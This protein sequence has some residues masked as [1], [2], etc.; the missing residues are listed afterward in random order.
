M[1]ITARL[2]LLTR[3]SGDRTAWL[4]RTGHRRVVNG[5]TV[6]VCTIA[7]HGTAAAQADPSFQASASANGVNQSQLG[8][9]IA[10]ASSD[11]AATPAPG[12]QVNARAFATALRGAVGVAAQSTLTASL[13]GCDEAFCSSS[14][15]AGASMVFHDLRFEGPTQD[16]EVRLHLSIGGSLQNSSGFTLAN[17]AISAAI[18][19]YVAQARINVSA[20]IE[21]RKGIL[22]F[23]RGDATLFSFKDARPPTS[24]FRVRDAFGSGQTCHGTPFGTSDSAIYSGYGWTTDPFIVPTG[25]N[26][27]LTV[28]ISTDS[29]TSMASVPEDFIVSLV[30]QSQFDHT[31][32]FPRS[33]PVFDLPDGY[34]VSSAQA[35]I[36]V[37]QWLGTEATD[38]TIAPTIAIALS[39]S[40]NA[41]GWH[42][43]EVV[44]SVSAEDNAGG[45]GVQSITCN[46]AGAQ[47]F[48]ESMLEGGSRSL[49]ITAEGATTVTCA[50]QD[51][52]G[53][54]S[55]RAVVVVR[56]DATPPT[57]RFG[58]PSPLANQA[59]WNNTDVS[60]PFA[61]S[62]A[63]SGVSSTQPSGGRLTLLGE[64][65]A[66][67]GSVVVVDLAGNSATVVSPAVKI[68]RTP[69]VVTSTQ[70]PP[71]NPQTWNNTDVSVTFLA[72]DD[73]SGVSGGTALVYVFSSEGAAQSTERRFADLAG[74]ST[75]ATVAGINIDKTAPEASVAFSPAALDVIV[76]GL[77]TLSGVN[78]AT[79]V[80]NWPRTYTITDVAG[81]VSRVTGEFERVGPH[82]RAHLATLQ[83]NGG[84]ILLVPDNSFQLGWG[85]RRDGTLHDLKQ[86]LSIGSRRNRVTTIA[87]FDARFN[88]STLRVRGPG[89][90]VQ[91]DDG[92]NDCDEQCGGR[93]VLPGLALLRLVTDRGV[94]RAQY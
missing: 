45:S 8:P 5:L 57:V 89:S 31:A 55:V 9:L 68:D 87:R 58:A 70:V 13:V 27:S 35:N 44:L 50:A 30:G 54:V 16:V 78:A 49:V 80:A 28:S 17:D 47:A 39:S 36:A 91:S 92:E 73:L 53:N 41:A 86:S 7:L 65:A 88:Q 84:R 72:S 15:S 60:V 38:D 85:A 75:T 94:V 74:N 37:N 76:S 14:A 66:V 1:T 83:Y 21:G 24:C 32:S 90:P 77:D 25:K 46:A 42:N 48:A 19:R 63:G 6:L 10:V 4:R 51:A 69:P 29:L 33:G 26:L 52:L 12:V 64:G 71:P 56:L 34:S 11:F 18:R 93:I 62:D 23:V 81:N 43:A 61:A 79:L 59:G 2:S 3:R 67:T 20:Q 82:I 40:P 22:G